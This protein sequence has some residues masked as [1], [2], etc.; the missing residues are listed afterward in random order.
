MEENRLAEQIIG[1]AIKVHKALGPGLLESAYQAC[2]LFEL[3][4]KDLLVENQFQCRS[5]NNK[6]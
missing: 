2:L 5:I 1:C 3:K 4:K 6:N